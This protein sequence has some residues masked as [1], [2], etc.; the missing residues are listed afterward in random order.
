MRLRGRGSGYKEGPDNK[1]SEE[2]LHLCISAKNPED[3]KKACRLVD[4]LLDKIHEDY[5]KYCQENNVNPIDTKIAMR[6]ESK[7]FGYNGK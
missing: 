5:K 6:I 2:P 4:D 3:M 1:E 7:N